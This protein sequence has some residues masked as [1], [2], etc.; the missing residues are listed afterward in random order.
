MIDFQNKHFKPREQDKLIG[1]SF[2]DKVTEQKFKNFSK[3]IKFKHHRYNTQQTSKSVDSE[4]NKIPEFVN[5]E[6]TSPANLNE[7]KDEIIEDIKQEPVQEEVV[8]V[9]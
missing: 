6:I 7:K 2:P 9:K 4:Y 8:E 3:I 1:N 5:Q